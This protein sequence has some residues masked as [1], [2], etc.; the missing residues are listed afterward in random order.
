MNREITGIGLR[1]RA[2]LPERCGAVV[3][4]VNGQPPGLLLIRPR[5]GEVNFDLLQ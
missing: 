3:H 5:D 4:E 2:P 1:A